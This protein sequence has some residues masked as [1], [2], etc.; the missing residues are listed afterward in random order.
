MF[1]LQILH[2]LKNSMQ[3]E[4]KCASVVYLS[5][6]VI[7]R[8]LL[9]RITCC[10]S[11]IGSY[12]KQIS[13][14][15]SRPCGKDMPRFH[16]SD[17]LRLSYLS[18]TLSWKRCVLTVPES[19]ARLLFDKF[20]YASILKQ[21]FE[22]LIKSSVWCQLFLSQQKHTPQ[23]EAQPCTSFSFY[24]FS[25]QDTDATLTQNIWAGLLLFYIKS[26]FYSSG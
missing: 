6:H 12:Q 7:H 11:A 26:E 22:L 4:R 21:S 13:R 17:L 2:R 14:H 1:L 23:W 24:G 3:F 16:I 25:A 9:F 20:T 18:A 8:S 10:K 15:F 19:H 5:K